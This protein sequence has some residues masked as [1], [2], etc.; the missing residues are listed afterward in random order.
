MK[1]LLAIP[2]HPV[3]VVM[4][5]L[6]GALA[7]DLDS[8]EAAGAVKAEGLSFSVWKAVGCFLMGFFWLAICTLIGVENFGSGG[9]WFPALL[10]L[11]L[12]FVFLFSGDV[13]IT[14]WQSGH[15][16]AFWIGFGLSFVF[17]V[18]AAV[19]IMSQRT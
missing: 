13:A 12:G 14:T 11:V 15:Q 18:L 10:G 17:S 1:R 19:R 6:L 5:I 4:L 16:C 2:I 8:A 7:L 9:G 3:I